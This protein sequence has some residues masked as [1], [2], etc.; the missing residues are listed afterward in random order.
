MALS[1]LTRRFLILDG[2]ICLLILAWI[3]PFAPAQ[4]IDPSGWEQLIPS[5][6][7]D[8]RITCQ[9]SNNNLDAIKFRDRYFIAFRSAPSHFASKKTKLY[10]MSSDGLEALGEEEFW[11]LEHEIHLGNDMREP[12]FS[13][14]KDSLRLYFFEG[15][16]RPHKFEP[17]HIWM[18]KYLSTETWSDQ[19]DMKLD[20]YVNW[21]LRQRSDTLY[22]SAYYGKELYSNTHLG[23]QRLFYSLDGDN[24][25]PISEEAQL[26]HQGVEE[27]EFIFDPQGDLWGTARLEGDGAMVIHARANDLSDWEVSYTKDKYD[28]ALLFEHHDGIYLIARRN[29]DGN[30]SKSGF[31]LY[32][33]LRYSFTKKK[34]ALYQLN[35]VTMSI[36]WI[37][38]LP[39]TGDTAFPGII[40]LGEGKFFLINYSNNIHGR[41]MNWI[42]GQLRKTYIYKTT[43]DMNEILKE[44]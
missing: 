19:R 2:I 40:D 16:K 6:D 5:D 34:T 33:L 31:R 21:R 14:Y 41:E 1:R 7:I 23:D 8:V 32:N 38:D 30:A 3:N 44:N 37:K 22:M 43:L 15:G 27:G 9:K 12:R 36:D 13:I 25:D 26:E 39:S 42:K 28:S 20:G 17:Q 29:V 24:W 4:S 10:V 11:K 18:T 35:Q